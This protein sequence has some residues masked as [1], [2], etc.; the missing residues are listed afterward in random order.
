MYNPYNH[1]EANG[2]ADLLESICKMRSIPFLNLYYESNL[3]PWDPAFVQLAYSKDAGEGGI[4]P[5]ETGHAIIAPRFE[6]FVDTL[7]L[8]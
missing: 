3:R 1:P 6:A 5:D 4:H 7:L 8:H 2:Y